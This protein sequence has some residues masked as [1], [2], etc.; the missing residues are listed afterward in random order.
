MVDCAG[1]YYYN[2]GCNGG[3]TD[4]AIQYA[5]DAGMVEDRYYPYQ[6]EDEFCIY[7]PYMTVLKPNGH[8]YVNPNNAKALKT[9][10]ADGPVSV[11]VDADSGVF[12]FYTSGI[13]NSPSCGTDIDHAIVAVGYGVDP[14][15]GEYYIVRNSWGSSWGDRGYLKIAIV[16]GVGICAI[17][18]APVYPTYK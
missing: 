7:D 10:I 5:Q 6:A 3:W 18:K 14:N 12:Q 9:A 2:D 11:G 17:Q 1:L 16:D 8:V 4:E 13:L 15:K